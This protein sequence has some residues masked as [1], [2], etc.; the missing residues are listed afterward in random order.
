MKVNTIGDQ[1]LWQMQ[2]GLIEPN[3]CEWCIL[4]VSIKGLRF[5][6]Q[7]FWNNFYESIPH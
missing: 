2:L 5:A 6:Q 3:G 7:H 4:H 1:N